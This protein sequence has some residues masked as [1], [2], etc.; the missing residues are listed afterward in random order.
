MSFDN[1][2]YQKEYRAE[3]KRNGICR[4]CKND[5]CKKSKIFCS[6]HLRMHREYENERRMKDIEKDELAALKRGIVS[7]IIAQL[8]R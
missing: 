2:K 4:R 6:N 5:I 7:G 8:T 1:N 3:K